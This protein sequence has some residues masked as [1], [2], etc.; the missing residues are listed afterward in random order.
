M[1]VPV[2][3]VK[4]LLL[5][6]L[7]AVQLLAIIAAAQVELFSFV[8]QQVLQVTYGAQGQQPNVLL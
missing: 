7:Q 2:V 4:L 8:H 5:I 3:A 6:P 1:V